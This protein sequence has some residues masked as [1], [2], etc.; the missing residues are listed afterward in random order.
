MNR[1]H[2]SWL[3]ALALLLI[4][5]ALGAA[6]RAWLDRN[7]VEAG[8]S[9]T[10]NVEVEGA[11]AAAPDF[12]PLEADFRVLG[13]Q[14]SRQVSL[15]SGR[16]TAKTLWAVGLEPRRQGRIQLPALRVGTEQT[17]A[18]E[19]EVR[20]A[21]DASVAGARGDVFIEVRAEPPDPYVQQ[22][23]RYTVKLYSAQ[24]LTDG[25]LS[26]P[27]ADG[28]VVRRLGQG[29]DTSFF[30]TV[31]GRRYRVY[32]RHYALTPERSGRIEIG[33]LTFQGSAL[34]GGDP[35]GFFNR[36]RRLSAASDAVS[37]QV[38]PRP[39]NAPAGAWLPAASLQLQD[40]EPLPAELH[41]GD[42]VTRVVRL[43]AQGL[44]FEQLPELAPTAPAGAEIYPDKADTRTRDDG[45]WLQG[46]RVQK[47]AFV[48]GRAG[49]LV[50][51][52]IRVDW[53]NT[54]ADRPAVAVL[55][56]RTVRVLPAASGAPP[57]PDAAAGRPA[58]TVAESAPARPATAVRIWRALAA[59]AFLLWLATLWLWRWRRAAP[60]RQAAA[61][62]DPAP[63][64][65]RADFLRACS[66]GDLAAAEHALVRWAGATRQDLRNAGELAA[67]V[68]DPRQQQALAELQRVRYAGAAADGLAGRLADAF[69][70]GPAWPAAAPTAASPLPPLYPERGAPRG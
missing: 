23:V 54:S 6:P 44:A 40:E 5:P 1:W 55:P 4:A 8:E 59:A 2:C 30:A 42:P 37:L 32:E 43:K 68:T 19:L 34:A 62:P 61:G 45:E 20:A 9:V 27:A 63:G 51:P 24:D 12:S 49:T 52:E 50:L 16:A 28:L 10:L 21:A 53:W 67:I 33:P 46:E 11:S 3:A 18:L 58:A 48:P 47:F 57:A 7:T 64:A 13:T 22:Q 60:P 31:G 65:A 39:A 69:R 17:A 35:T 25:N 29:Q 56:A 66:L 14:S 15:V 41:V 70:Q 38:R 26:E 36:G